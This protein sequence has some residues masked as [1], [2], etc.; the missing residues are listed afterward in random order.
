LSGL[1]KKT[2]KEAFAK[3]RG[4]RKPP[5]DGGPHGAYPVVPTLDP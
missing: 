1:S 5:V 2:L 3:P 4:K